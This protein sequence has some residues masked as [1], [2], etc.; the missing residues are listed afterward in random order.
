MELLSFIRPTAS[1]LQTIISKI[2]GGLRIDVK[3]DMIF[4][5]Q[6]YL[7]NANVKFKEKAID[8]NKE[9]KHLIIT[10]NNFGSKPTTV[11]QAYIEV[12][13][14]I[15]WKWLTKLIIQLKNYKMI[16]KICSPKSFAIINALP[17]GKNP[18]PHFLEVGKI[19]Y[20]AAV[21]SREFDELLHKNI[22][23]LNIQHSNEAK[24]IF[25]VLSR[26]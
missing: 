18:T 13:E 20:G 4:S 24:P 21:Q 23:V 26:F 15:K 5:D 3:F 11:I 6:N 19:W 9:R 12:Y 25:T 16:S 22:L 10:V 7:L 2:Q 17:H 1:L 14:V 8:G